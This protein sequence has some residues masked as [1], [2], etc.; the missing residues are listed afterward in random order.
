MADITRKSISDLAV[1]IG[2]LNIAQGGGQDDFVEITSPEQMTMVTGVHGDVIT[3]DTPNNVYPVN[4]SLLETSP[5]NSSLA[6][7]R[8]QQRA[9]ST[10]G[11]FAVTFQ[12]TNTGETLNGEAVITKEPD[13]TF[14]AAANNRQ[15][16]LMVASPRGIEYQA[17]TAAP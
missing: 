17:P 8:T 1:S 15:W 2:G 13:I 14:N 7:I 9:S 5:V 10:S 6:D 4:L 12:D 11:P 16:Q 3:F